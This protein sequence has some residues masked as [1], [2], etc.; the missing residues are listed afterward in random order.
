MGMALKRQKKEKKEKKER[1]KLLDID[2]GDQ[3]D[4]QEVHLFCKLTLCKNAGETNSKAKYL[5]GESM[6][7]CPIQK[8]DM[9]WILFLS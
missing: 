9:T 8:K 5:L 3:K 7:V 2:E 1:K 6:Q 4:D